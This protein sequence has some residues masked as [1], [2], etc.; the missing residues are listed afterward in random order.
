MPQPSSPRAALPRTEEAILSE[1]EKTAAAQALVRRLRAE[2][3]E[4]ERRKQEAA[5]AAV[6]APAPVLDGADGGVPLDV[7][8]EERERALAAEREAV[9]AKRAREAALRHMEVQARLAAL[10]PG[11]GT[12]RSGGED[13]GG[14]AEAAAADMASALAVA[15]GVGEEEPG[16]GGGGGGGGGRTRG[17]ARW[18]SS[19]G[20][21]RPSAVAA[22][23]AASM[24]SAKHRIAVAALPRLAAA[25]NSRAAAALPPL[26]QQHQQQQQ[27]KPAQARA[28]GVAAVQ[29]A[30][31]A[32][33]H[34]PAL[35]GRRDSAASGSGPASVRMALDFSQV[36]LNDSGYDLGEE[37]G[38]GSLVG[39]ED[40][41]GSVVAPA[42]HAGAQRRRQH[43]KDSRAYASYSDKAAAMSSLSNASV[44]KGRQPLPAANALASL[45]PR[46]SRLAE[47]R[48]RAAAT[49]LKSAALENATLSIVKNLE[50]HIDE[51]V[52]GAAARSSRHPAGA[53]AGAGGRGAPT[54]GPPP[55]QLDVTGGSPDF[56][57]RSTVLLR[58]LQLH[59]HQTPAAVKVLAA[60]QREVSEAQ[61]RLAAM[62]AETERLLAEEAAVHAAALELARERRAREAA[63]EARRAMLATTSGVGATT[64]VRAAHRR[65][66]VEG[67]WGASPAA[68]TATG[69]SGSPGGASTVWAP[70]ASASSSAAPSPVQAPASASSSPEA[71]AVPA[72][73]Q[74]HAS[75]VRSPRPAAVSFIIPL[76]DE[77]GE[78]EELPGGEEGEADAHERGGEEEEADEDAAGGGGSF[79]P[80]EGSGRSSPAPRT[81]G[82]VLGHSPLR[83]PP[84]PAAQAFLMRRNL[85]PQPEQLIASPR[86]RGL[87]YTAEDGHRA[88]TVIQAGARGLLARKRAAFLRADRLPPLPDTD[89]GE[90]EGAGEEE[91]EVAPVDA[92][93][94]IEGGEEVLEA[95][96]EQEEGEEEAVG[97]HRPP[98]PHPDV[99][100]AARRFGRPRAPFTRPE[101]AAVCIQAASR[102][103]AVRRRMRKAARAAILI[104]SIYRGFS[105]RRRRPLLRQNAERVA[106]WVNPAG[107]SYPVSMA[108]AEEGNEGAG[109]GTNSQEEGE[110][111]GFGPNGEELGS[112]GEVAAAPLQ[113]A[114]ETEAPAE[115]APAA[116]EEQAAR[117]EA[118]TADA[119]VEGEAAADA[120]AAEPDATAEEAAAVAA[121]AEAERDTGAAA[122]A[123]ATTEEN[124]A[125]PAAAEAPAPGDDADEQPLA[126]TNEEADDASPSSEPVPAAVELPAEADAEAE[127][128]EPPEPLSDSLDGASPAAPANEEAGAEAPPTLAAA[129]EE[130]GA[131]ILAPL[132]ETATDLGDAAFDA[133]AT[134]PDVS[135]QDSLSSPVMRK[136][137]PRTEEGD[138]GEA[139]GEETAP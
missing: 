112:G 85:S 119:A 138:G 93:P 12:R 139:G 19:A 92:S 94:E 10:K 11:G 131:A 67:R 36:P 53:R 82:Y 77:A 57:D 43:G 95:G 46:G 17:P 128:E 75:P 29:P 116:E 37:D 58:P 135:F 130:E 133:N 62:Q 20:E 35:G 73:Q 2:A 66:P 103:D 18:G 114:A 88:A 42:A 109:E 101:D 9:R 8:R 125:P 71:A 51:L 16:Y 55:L 80:W 81:S 22:A 60:R 13:D 69:G 137:M 72:H 5:L 59:E 28:S 32:A 33:S 56:V 74:Q 31:G 21:T 54:G 52:S 84:P 121:E 99:A 49:K 98:T 30:R 78:A 64:G 100:D 68:S 48:Q 41:G 79:A 132:G 39:E 106:Y 134:L 108:K 1:Q 115:A 26:P 105:V 107:F 25:A 76:H 122:A 127:A 50:G 136:L 83:S 96:G 126:P 15:A 120:A 124:S 89:E 86:R 111:D 70:G 45:A 27:Q 3:R 61:K 63:E 7:A 34:L 87:A 123:D 117:E 40:G 6:T 129:E 4:R 24:E 65:S 38:D 113:E 118:A 14:A 102:G 90:G 91:G 47:L 23:S 44:S 97:E 104:Q 110:D